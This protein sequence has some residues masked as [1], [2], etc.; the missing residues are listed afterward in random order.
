[1]SHDI[2]NKRLVQS[3]VELM[4]K[5]FKSE[6]LI[7]QAQIICYIIYYSTKMWNMLSVVMLGTTLIGIV[8]W[9]PYN[10]AFAGTIHARLNSSPQSYTGFEFT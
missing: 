1:M 7:L 2:N 6:G 10:M 9:L 3:K 8:S 4:W 5:D